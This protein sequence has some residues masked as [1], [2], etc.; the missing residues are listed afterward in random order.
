LFVVNPATPEA[1]KQTKIALPGP[2]QALT[3]AADG[4][5]LVTANGNGTLYVL[6]LDAK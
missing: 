5:H 2:V 4:R 1:S 3:V 6:R